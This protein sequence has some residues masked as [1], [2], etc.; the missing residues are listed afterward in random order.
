[1][2][3]T[4]AGALGFGVAAIVFLSVA[5]WVATRRI[6]HSPYPSTPLS[7]AQSG[8]GAIFQLFWL[9]PLVALAGFGIKLFQSFGED[10]A[11]ILLGHWPRTW[12]VTGFVIELIFTLS[13]AAFAMRIYLRVLAPDATAEEVRA[14][15]RRAVMYA[16][17]FW[18]VAIAATVAGIGLVVLVK[19][20]D[21]GQVMGSIG[22]ISYAIT[23]VAA[24]SRPAIAIGLARPVREALRILRENWFGAAVTLILAALPLGLVFFAAG[25]LVRFL[26][27]P[28][29]MALL[30][31]VPI[32]ALSALCYAAFEGVIAAM[33]K[34][35]M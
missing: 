1:V 4:L 20:V 26:Q 10:A 22:Y 35:I 31:Q 11:N 33:Y 18:A 24:L 25:L 13:W 19:G 7:A 5:V 32:T 9:W 29:A 16:L 3:L 23:I 28:M 2:K 17:S 21:N 27:M 30:L 12:S 34:R 15:T 6:L 8:W 14:R